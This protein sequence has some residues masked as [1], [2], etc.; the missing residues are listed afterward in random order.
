MP[1]DPH[2]LIGDF[3]D[4]NV[5]A[6]EFQREMQERY[7]DAA[8]KLLA[9][10]ERKEVGATFEGPHE[11]GDGQRLLIEMYDMRDPADRFRLE[12][13]MARDT[14]RPVSTNMLDPTDEHL[15]F[16]VYFQVGEEAYENYRGAMIGEVDPAPRTSKYD[17]EEDT[18]GLFARIGRRLDK[19]VEQF[20]DL[21]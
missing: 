20:L 13:F 12:S 2:D 3:G 17:D 16:M 21:F 4:A 9:P 1:D 19:W 15:E 5:G 18:G 6:E 10:S 14:V 7:Q 11:T 8:Q